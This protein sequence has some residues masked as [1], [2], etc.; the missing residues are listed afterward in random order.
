MKDRIV[1]FPNRYEF[2]KVSENVYDLVPK[3]GKVT[4]MGT[5]T[6]KATLLSDSTSALYGGID[7]VDGAFKIISNL[8]GSKTQLFRGAYTGNGTTARRIELPF[9]PGL[10]I[11]TANT[12]GI[13]CIKQSI[14]SIIAGEI[15]VDNIGMKSYSSYGIVDKGFTVSTSE[16]AYK[17]S[18]TENVSSNTSNIIYYYSAIL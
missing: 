4:E 5:P 3:P 10:V 11:I 13:V 8:V 6:N 18:E 2:F 7:T 16:T 9:Q 14:R 12:Y 17:Y 15:P 1:E